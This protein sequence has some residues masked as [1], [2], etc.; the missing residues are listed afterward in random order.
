MQRLLQIMEKKEQI[1][2]FL[3]SEIVTK[4]LQ[5]KEK[6]SCYFKQK[7]VDTT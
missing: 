2:K 4:Y 3:N 1:K 7:A 5:S 6:K